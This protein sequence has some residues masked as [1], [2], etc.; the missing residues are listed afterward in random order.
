MMFLMGVLN[1]KQYLINHPY[2]DGLYHPFMLILG[3]F[4]IGF[5]I[6]GFYSEFNEG[7]YWFYRVF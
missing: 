4:P 3:W 5:T 2:F 1:V 7:Q 6:Y